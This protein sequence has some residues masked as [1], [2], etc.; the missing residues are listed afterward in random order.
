MPSKTTLQSHLADTDGSVATTL[1]SD[2][3]DLEKRLLND[4]QRGFP[5]SSTPYADIA[6]ELG[7][8]EDDVI[9]CLRRLRARGALTR[10]GP[11]FKPNAA[12]ASTLAAMDVPIERLDDV[13]RLVNNFAEVNHNYEREHDFNL[14]FVVTA[15]DADSV[16]RVLDDIRETTGLAVID[17]PM[18][19]PYHIDL[20]FSLWR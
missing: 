17:L 15:A 14:W 6:R 19:A 1:L 5:L 11:V 12:G 9:A 16:Q 20:G 3:A 10:I 18:E 13:A 8:G 7:V 2:L 4:Y